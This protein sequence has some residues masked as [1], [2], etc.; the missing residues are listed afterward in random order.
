ME[1]PS[2]SSEL[3]EGSLR[4]SEDD[5]RAPTSGLPSPSR[6]SGILVRYTGVERHRWKGSTKLFCTWKTTGPSLQSTRRCLSGQRQSL[7]GNIQAFKKA[8]PKL[9]GCR[10]VQPKLLIKPGRS[11]QRARSNVQGFRR[12]PSPSNKAPVVILPSLDE[13]NPGRRHCLLGLSKHPKMFIRF[14]RADSSSLPS[15]D[16]TVSGRTHCLFGLSDHPKM[17]IRS[18]RTVCSPLDGLDETIPARAG[19]LPVS[20]EFPYELVRIERTACHR[21]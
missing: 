19:G 10:P 8:R 14:K 11:I 21:F 3:P 9:T 17:L 16:E 18:N 15:L 13:A 4:S 7:A 12:F 2:R 1:Y 6:S 20:S 5:L